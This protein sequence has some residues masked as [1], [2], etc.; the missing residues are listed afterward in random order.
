MK[1]NESGWG[2]NI[3]CWKSTYVYLYPVQTGVG[4]RDIEFVRSCVYLTHVVTYKTNRQQ[5]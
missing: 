5:V 3:S 1:Q 4:K 2:D